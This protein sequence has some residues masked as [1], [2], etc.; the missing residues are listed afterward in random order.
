MIDIT[1]LTAV[2]QTLS[3][4]KRIEF[5][6]HCANVYETGQSPI[7]DAEYDREYYAVC[8]YLEKHDP[9]NDF[10]NEVGGLED[11]LYGTTVK[12]KVLMGSLSKSLDIEQFDKWLIAT[13]SNF[14][15]LSF[16]LE[17][18]IDGLSLGLTYENHQLVQALTRGNGVAGID[19][20]KNAVH[21]CGVKK[22]IAYDGVVEIRG[23]CYKN[24]Q[25]FYKKWH[26]SVGGRFKNPRNFASGSINQL[27]VEVTKE[28]ELDFVA[29]EIVQKDFSTEREKMEFL[30]KNGFST[31]RSS[32]KWTKRGLSATEVVRAAK[33]YMESISRATLP[34]DIDGV[35]VKLDN[36]K[37][38]ESMGSVANGRKP[39]AN[40]AIKFPPEESAPTP[41][42]KIEANVGRTG[43]IVPVGIV[44]PVELGGA[45]ISRVSLHNYGA[46]L[47]GKIRL[48]SQVI[49]AKKGDII[50]QV[51]K[52]TKVGDKD[53][54]IPTH[55]P[56]CGQ[57]LFWN[58]TK[59]HLMC[60]NYDCLAQLNAKIENWF[61]KIGVKG[62]GKGTLSKLTDPDVLE[63]EGKPI[64]S[65]LDEMYYMLDY[66]RRSEH[67]FRKYAY[68]K[69]FF[70]EKSYENI[71]TSVKSVNEIPLHTFIEALG[72][73]K[74]GSMAKDIV[75]IA[76]SIEEIDKLTVAEVE[77][78]PGFGPIKAKNFIDGWKKSRKEISTL[79]KYVKVKVIQATSDKLKDK[80]FCFT[81]SFSIPRTDLQKLVVENGGKCG[82]VGKDTILVWDG[83]ENGNKFQKAKANGN[84]II[85]EDDF[86]LMIA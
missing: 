51:I 64:I 60:D 50:P 68:L 74:I 45:M 1:K 4:E 66:D 19:V 81:G 56:S 6:R 25:D 31:L 55:C 29:Y 72:I 20:T 10:L 47:T 11:H 38:A 30:E 18:K 9:D 13:Y 78:I 61:K 32:S 21:V 85:S 36:V 41:I 80:K 69:E 62:I 35:V 12:H 58:D 83:E 7:S 84:T 76:S 22:T 70:G 27:D 2:D 82:S 65:S 71:I 8:D 34:Y 24:R 59:T 73:A 75:D 77:V 23:E 5:L 49:I 14:D 26:T 46:L 33:I 37:K 52:V 79:L 67:P 40:R 54:E 17:H 48:G 86:R 15:N 57:L 39:K 28:R 43:V 63:W 44:A 3:I 42:I 53:V 16:L